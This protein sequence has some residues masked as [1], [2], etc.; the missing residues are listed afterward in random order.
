[1]GIYVVL[2]GI[3]DTGNLGTVIRTADAM[4]L[5][6]VITVNC[7]D[8]YNPKT[9]RSTMGSLF[10]MTVIDGDK[11]QVFGA[12]KQADIKTYA[13]V[14]DTDAV[15]VTECGFDKNKGRAIF[16]G[17][18]GNGL[19]DDVAAMCDCRVTIKMCGSVNSLNAASAASI[20]MWELVR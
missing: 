1:M 6:A 16:I 14:V 12:L 3:Q 20:L 5:S 4:G 9:I 8:L 13:A 7:C 17:N 15:S 19:P 10:R 2:V 11:E 18:E